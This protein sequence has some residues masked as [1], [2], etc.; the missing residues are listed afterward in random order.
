MSESTINYE[1]DLAL[2]PISQ[3]PLIFYKKMAQ[4]AQER[5]DK[6]ALVFLEINE[7]RSAET[8]ALFSTCTSVEIVQD[9]QG[10]DRILQVVV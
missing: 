2:Y 8:K 4:Y 7:F 9:M 5:M 3:D 1:P 10:K 6:G